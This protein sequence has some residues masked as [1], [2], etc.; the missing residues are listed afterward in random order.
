V[1]ASERRCADERGAADPLVVR[2]LQA[3]HDRHLPLWRVRGDA[4]VIRGFWRWW[5]GGLHDSTGA[6]GLLCVAATLFVIAYLV[7]LAVSR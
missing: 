5:R 4:A 1:H 7:V 3:L 2:E 6:I